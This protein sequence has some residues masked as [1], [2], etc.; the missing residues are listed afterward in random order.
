MKK[1]AKLLALLLTL[2]L[3]IV[4]TVTVI[5]AAENETPHADY[6]PKTVSYNYQDGSAKALNNTTGTNVMGYL[7]KTEDGNLYY[8]IAPAFNG[9]TS[10]HTY[11]SYR[12]DSGGNGLVYLG[13]DINNASSYAKDCTASFVTLDLDLATE[14]SLPDY[15]SISLNARGMKSNATGLSSSSPA[16]NLYIR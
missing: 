7:N 13:A 1:R 8:V 14:T 5:S 16:G 15:M 9:N 6:T 3:L 11:L 12:D 2:A 10:A 4:C